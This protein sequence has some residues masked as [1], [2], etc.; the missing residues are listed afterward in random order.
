M[1]KLTKP[2]KK[3]T[4]KL[5]K[6]FLFCLAIL[7]LTQIYLSNRLADWGQELKEIQRQTSLLEEENKN[8]RLELISSNRLTNLH[9]LAEEQG[10]VK[11]P[12]TINLSLKIPVALNY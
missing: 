12:Q 4:N 11:N 1:N 2:D 7:G 3:Q 5:F 6:L 8:Y 9:V 10:F